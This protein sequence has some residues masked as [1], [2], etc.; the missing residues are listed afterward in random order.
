MKRSCAQKQLYKAAAFF[1][2]R[3]WLIIVILAVLAITYSLIEPYWI[4][5]KVTEIRDPDIPEAFSQ[6]RIVFMADI[7]HG[8]FFSRERVR[9]VVAMANDLRPDMVVLGG[10]YVYGDKK[11]TAPCFEELSRLEAPYGVFAVLGNHDHWENE[12]TEFTLEVISKSQINL[13]DNKALWIYKDGSRI[14]LGGVG[15]Y[16]TD[17]QDIGPTIAGVRQEDF[18]ILVS[19]NPDYCESF[20]TKKIDLV[21]SGHTHGGQVT[22]FGLYSPFLPTFTG[23]KYRSGLVELAH[24]KVLVTNGIGTVFLPLRFCARPQINLIVLN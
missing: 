16:W 9:D 20:S 5:V 6:F 18:V 21:L 17:S 3:A 22:F 4:E 8:P 14:R 2:K 13:I 15:D 7:H 23:Q 12:S 24:T 19:H 10:D 11:Y 1:K